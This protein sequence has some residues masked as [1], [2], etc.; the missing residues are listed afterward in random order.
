MIPGAGLAERQAAASG[1]ARAVVA[2]LLVGL[3]AYLNARFV[4]VHFSIGGDLLDSGWFAYIMAAG[5]PWLMSPKSVGDLGYF[6]Y[7]LSPYLSALSVL[8]HALGADGFIALALHQGFAY[9]LLAAGLFAI[10]ARGW[11]GWRS[12]VLLLTAMLLLLLGDVVLQIASFPHFEVATLAFCTLGAALWQRSH[13][14][15]AMLAFALACTVREDGGLYASAFLLVLA[16]FDDE[17]AIWR[18][19][20]LYLGL[21]T[22]AVSAAM[23]YIKG[24]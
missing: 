1:W 14:G 10:V 3:V 18:R 2:A 20:G 23:F 4:L 8:F 15:A 13:R 9:G 12:G 7:H 5:D 21:L 19:P 16:G 6:N 11:S 24:R 22:A 17:N